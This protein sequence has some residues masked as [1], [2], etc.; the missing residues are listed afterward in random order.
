MQISLFNRKLRYSIVDHKSIETGEHR[1]YVC[2]DCG[3]AQIQKGSCEVCHA[4]VLSK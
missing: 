3:H 1:I 2:P 4:K